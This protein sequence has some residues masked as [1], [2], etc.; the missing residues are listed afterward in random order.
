MQW[1]RT[2][3]AI[4]ATALLVVGWVA[5]GCGRS[6][7]TIQNP[8]DAG[9]GVEA[10]PGSRLWGDGVSGPSGM[11]LGCI[12][13]RHFAVVVRVHNGTERAVT[14]LSGGGEQPIAHLIDR[15]G[16]QVR[17]APAPPKGDLVIAGLRPW[18]RSASAPVAVPAGRDAWIQSNFV[19]RDC[20]LLPPD[21][22]VPTNGDITLTYGIDGAQG[23]QR[24][25]VPAA[26]L[27]LTRARS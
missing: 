11:N 13:G 15:V 2:P 10:G 3:V 25:V 20:A 5:S 21:Q 22:A 4:A 1:K 12:S 14:I 9:D 6:E 8:F 16:V 17:L 27:I 7:Q 18:S 24:I 26:R 19:M 23:T